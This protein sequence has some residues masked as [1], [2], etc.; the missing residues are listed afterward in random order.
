MNP[1][2]KPLGNR[3]LIKPLEV[4]EKTAGGIFL[5]DSA[6]DRDNIMQ[7]DAIIVSMGAMAFTYEAD[8]KFIDYPDKPKVGDKVR[9]IKYVGDVFVG[10][11]GEKYR[12]LNDVDILANKI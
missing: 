2:F 8:G 6:I 4:E 7:Q 1:G 11:D 3:V 5:P 12:L 9:I 10:D